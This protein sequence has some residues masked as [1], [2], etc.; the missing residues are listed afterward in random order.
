[1]EFKSDPKKNGIPEF[2]QIQNRMELTA[3]QQ[4]KIDTR[5]AKVEP[6][7]FGMHRT[8]SDQDRKI[9]E[10]IKATKKLNA[11]LKFQN[12]MARAKQKSTMIPGA[13]WDQSVCK[14]IHPNEVEKDMTN[15]LGEKT[16]PELTAAYNA[17]ASSK[18]KKT[19]VKFKDKKTA[20]TRLEE[21]KGSPTNGKTNGKTAPS[22]GAIQDVF[23]F[24]KG[25]VR[26]K[27]LEKLIANLGSMIPKSKLGALAAGLSGIEWR[28]S[29]SPDTTGN[30]STKKLP[31]ELKSEKG[32]KEREYGLYKKV[33]PK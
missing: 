3:E 29:G 30:L 11:D 25:S 9:A 10:E 6:T 14:W 32:E 22:R 24:R 5:M 1:M 27:L 15:K 23:N 28:I 20:M 8:L 4:V 31:F 19:V 13:V 16:I 26:E 17:I 18:G 2:L 7:G 21:I 33:Q 12:R